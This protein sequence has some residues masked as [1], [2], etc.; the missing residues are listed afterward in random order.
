M[1]KVSVT[2]DKHIPFCWNVSHHVGIG[3]MCPNRPTDVELVKLL[4]VKSPRRPEYAVWVQRA[5]PI[6]LGGN[7]TIDGKV[8]PAPR[9]KILYSPTAAYTI[10]LLNV[11]A[12]EADEKWWNT[13]ATNPTVSKP[14]RDELLYN[15]EK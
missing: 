3:Q 7:R 12:R 10:V 6:K 1:A 13:L 2:A 9:H 11:S 4:M 8:S 15:I 14:L 5:G